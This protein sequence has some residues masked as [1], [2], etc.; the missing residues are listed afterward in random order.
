MK[1]ITGPE[2]VSVT[3]GD[4]FGSISVKLYGSQFICHCPLPPGLLHRD[5]VSEFTLSCLLLYSAVD[6]SKDFLQG[7]VRILLISN[8]M[9]YKS[10]VFI[11][12]K[13]KRGELASSRLTINV[14][15]LKIS[16]NIFFLK[17]FEVSLFLFKH[18]K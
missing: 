3:N 6:L 8:I 10:Q 11:F 14:S 5:S 2:D 9:F 17:G 13:R 7:R 15:S 18:R 1:F 16:F 12:I 4:G